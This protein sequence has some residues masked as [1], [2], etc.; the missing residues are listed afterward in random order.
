MSKLSQ[1]RDCPLPSHCKVQ[2]SRTLADESLL[3]PCRE[4]RFLPPP[5]VPLA[6]H[7]S[8]VPS[9]LVSHRQEIDS[10]I[11][12]SNS[13]SHPPR[14]TCLFRIKRKRHVIGIL[15]TVNPGHWGTR[16]LT[17]K[18]NNLMRLSPKRQLLSLA[19]VGRPFASPTSS[20]R[21]DA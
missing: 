11:K 10:L 15:S 13:V 18:R 9:P 5:P 14:G 8:V 7:L 1:S 3:F 12:Q 2:P 16:R 21:Q 6:A 4:S 17:I 19:A 20:R